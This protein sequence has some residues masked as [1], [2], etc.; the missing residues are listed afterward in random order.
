MKLCRVCHQTFDDSASFCPTDGQELVVDPMLGAVLN[1]YRIEAWLAEGG[2]GVLYRAEHTKIKRTAAVKLLKREYLANAQM[3]ERFAREARAVVKIGHPHLIDVFDV[4]TTPEGQT[5]YIMELLRGRSLKVR[6]LARPMSFSE[7]G[8]L[9]LDACEALHAAHSH[10]IIH[11]DLKPDNIFLVEQADQPPF[12]KVLDFGIAKLVG[13]DEDVESKLTKTGMVLGTPQYMSPEQIE[14]AAVVDARADVYALGIILYEMATG[15]LP[16]R[17]G[18]LT[19]VIK[20]HLVDPPLKFEQARLA[21]GVPPELEAVVL[22][23]LARKPD[24]RYQNMHELRADLEHILKREQPDAATWWIQRAKTGQVRP[25]SIPSYLTE[26]GVIPLPRPPETPSREFARRSG[27]RWRM[28]AL[29]ALAASAGLTTTVALSVHKWSLA[30]QAQPSPPPTEIDTAALHSKALQ[31]ITAGLQDGDPMVRQQA[32]EMLAS[33]RDPRHRTLVEPLLS[34]P[35]LQVRA[36]AA[37]GLGALASRGSLPALRAAHGKDPHVDVWIDEA[38]LNLGDENARGSLRTFLETGDDAIRLKAALVLTD[39]G[40][41]TARQF[42]EDLARSRAAANKESADLVTLNLLSHLARRGDRTA[43]AELLRR[44]AEGSETQQA[45]VAELVARL[46]EEQGKSKLSQLG[47]N[48]TSRVRLLALRILAS[49]DDLSGFDLFIEI[50]SDPKQPPGER[51]LAARGLGAAGDKGAL[52]TLA[53]ALDEANPAVRLAAA[54]A[55]LEILASDPVR[56]GGASADWATAALSDSSWSVREQAAAVLGDAEA[57]FSIPLLAKAIHDQRVE[58]RRTAARSLGRTRRAAAV[59]YLAE[60]LDDQ[61]GEVRMAALQSIGKI[62]DRSA[63]PILTRHLSRATP[64]ERVV[65]AGQLALLGDRSQ[66]PTLIEALRA[67]DPELRQLALEESSG[68]AATALQVGRTALADSSPAVRL[69]AALQ[70]AHA[71]SSEGVATLQAGVKEGGFDGL[72]AFAA[73]Q[74]LGVQPVSAFDLERF[75]AWDAPRREQAAR[76][77]AQLHPTEAL[78]L[79]GE[80]IGDLD[81]RVRMA[82][83]E[84]L[85]DAESAPRDRRIALLHGALNGTDPALRAK[86]GLL[87]A[88]L[89]LKDSPAGSPAPN[90][91]EDLSVAPDFSTEEAADSGAIAEE[92]ENKIN[93]ESKEE[94]A[95]AMAN[96]ELALKTG[97]YETAIR[98]LEKA[99]RLNPKAPV[100]YS[101]GEAYRKLGDQETEHEAQLKSYRKAVQYYKKSRDKRAAAIASELEELYLSK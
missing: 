36:A 25:E 7:F 13:S 32:I 58:V 93:E 2:L 97:K 4:G 77:A 22:K 46:G 28:V 71:G 18:T 98:E 100:A 3:T 72:R 69:A 55:V 74:K 48:K 16:F 60:A 101:L 78:A 14:G 49:L 33:G 37:A 83:L 54:G 85:F 10:G 15:R 95:L 9:F 35:D 43:R 44:M 11:R 80:A 94:S 88:K 99:H 52:P 92:P 64:A 59:P 62:R 82:A 34:D 68:D 75:A 90:A 50:L 42:I 6:Q 51:L 47:N 23:A 81:P 31:K 61:A 67:P 26:T 38:A 86:A 76:L 73:L 87:L 70:L 57:T 30:P 91:P 45:A 40:D 65:A 19:A 27:K 96:G 8:P 29:L 21:E 84:T 17:G 89:A 79:L 12:L 53:P 5:Y 41:A 20:A 1:G 39:N 56:M 24:D 63:A 66:L